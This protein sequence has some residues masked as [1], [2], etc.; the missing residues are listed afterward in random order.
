VDSG[1]DL[2]KDL[3][4]FPGFDTAT[5]ADL[6]S[7]LELFLDEV[8]WSNESDFRDLL[9]SEHV[10]LNGRLAKVYGVEATMNGDF[11]KIRM[12]GG[13]RAGILTHPYLMARFASRSESSPIHRGVFLARGVLGQSLRPP[14]EAFTPLAPDLHPEMTT[15]ERVALQTKATACMSC[16]GL[17]NPLGFTMERFDAIGRY[18]EVDRGK[19]VDDNGSYRAR[20]GKAVTLKGAREVAKFLASSSEAQDAFT[21]QLFH[22]LVQQPVQAYGRTTQDVLRRS[23]ASQGFNI[24]K[25]AVNVMAA[26]ALV[27][28]ENGAAVLTES[29][30]KARTGGS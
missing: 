30:T 3:Q 28:R 7:S 13:K 16:H 21:E 25:L 27:G 14:P 8:V 23:F 2:S 26:S 5:V 9:L 6:R 29:R 4:K 1:S 15:R 10:F 20:D 18:R 12:D 24:R 22:H 11:A 17:I 19:P